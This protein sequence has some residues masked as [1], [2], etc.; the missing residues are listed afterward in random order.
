MVRHLE[1]SDDF[2]VGAGVNYEQAP[3][4]DADGKERQFDLWT[5]CYTPREL[6]LMAAAAGLDVLGLWSVTPGRYDKSPPDLE[7][8]E[9]L[10]IAQ[11]VASSTL[12]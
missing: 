7:H 8:P 1:D 11:R 9:L 6:R 4:K 12:F 10:L 3:V 5:A 2:D